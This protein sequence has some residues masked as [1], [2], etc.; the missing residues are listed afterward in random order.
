M[1]PINRLSEILDAARAC[2]LLLNNV[3]DDGW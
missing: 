3:D 2:K 1:K